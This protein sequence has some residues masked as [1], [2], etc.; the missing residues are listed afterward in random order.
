MRPTTALDENLARVRAHRSNIHRYRR[1]ADAKITDLERQFIA[2]RLAEE[3]A[4]IETLMSRT[5]PIAFDMP[6]GVAA[7]MNE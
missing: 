1:I 6:H 5:F 7:S 3:Q 2:R 4:A